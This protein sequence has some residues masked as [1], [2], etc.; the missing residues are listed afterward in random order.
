MPAK[1][2]PKA[3]IEKAEEDYR[4]VVALSRLRAAP[5]PGPICFHAQQCAEKYLKALLVR[6]RVS[7]PYTHDLLRLLD[8]LLQS[9]PDLA[10]LRPA[11]VQLKP[12]AAE[13]RYPGRAVTPVQAQVARQHM[14][15]VRRV[16]RKVL[17]L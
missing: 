7:F 11:L 17:G 5:V 10:R 15:T 14:Q 1:D 9:H 12:L 8:L 13:V 3:W 6:D 2:S 16:L 4:T